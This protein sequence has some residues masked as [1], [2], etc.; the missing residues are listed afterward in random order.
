MHVIFVEPFFPR[1]QREHVRGLK[2]VG[3]AVSAI[4][5]TPWDQLD[6]ELRGWLTHYEHIR[7]VTDEAHLE[8]AVRR[9][10]ARGWIDR[11]EATIESHVLPTA[12]VRERCGI[13]GTLSRTAWLCRDKAAMKDALRA[14]GV[15]CAASTRVDSA[16][17]VRDFVAAV[18]YP[19]ILKP[20]DGA[21]AAGT[22]RAG[23]DAELARA[24]DSSGVARGAA[25]IAEEF[26][27]GHEGFYD[28]L[29]IGGRVAMDFA[30]HY[31]PN[32]L[33]AMRARWISPQIVHTNRIDDPSYAELRQ[34]GQRVI[35]VLGIHDSPT[36]MEW[37]FGPKGLKFSEIGCRPPGVGTWDLYCAGNDIDLYAEWA[38]SVSWRAVDHLPSRSHAV[39]KVALRP[40]RDGHIVGYRGVRDI[41]RRY[42]EHLV[43]MHL[44]AEGTPTQPVANGYHAN[45]WIVLRHPD[46]D[47]LREM[48]DDVGRTVRVVAE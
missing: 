8:G 21:G 16:A 6:D 44:P 42:G 13:P 1:S 3:A 43:R 26:I 23:D 19:V 40:D 46:Y 31:F 17:A 29:T 25:A 2:A 30:C 36:H 48:L 38:R 11:L 39:G 28:T 22:Y 4:G 15:P 45:A 32:V 34:L 9:I 18:G 12:H 41:E 47:R 33:E 20:L 7:S 10:Q 37:F 5:E 35:D 14:A 24:L 27:E